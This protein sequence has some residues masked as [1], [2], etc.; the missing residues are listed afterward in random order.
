MGDRA[1]LGVLE[2]LYSEAPP[3]QGRG[4]RVLAQPARAGRNIFSR[5]L[6]GFDS[7]HTSY[8]DCT[9]PIRRL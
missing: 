5:L 3:P 8:T 2:S 9:A 1:F 4:G 7:A 6:Q